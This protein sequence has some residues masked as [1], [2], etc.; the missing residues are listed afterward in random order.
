LILVLLS[1]QS[2]TGQVMNKEQRRNK[3]VGGYRTIDTKNELAITAAELVLNNL[4]SGKGPTDDYSFVFPKGDSNK[5]EVKILRA[6][7]QV[8]AGMNFKL[9]LGI[10]GVGDS[11]IGGLK[12]TT[13]YK[14]LQGNFSV[15][16]YGK[17]ISCDRVQELSEA[18]DG[19]EVQE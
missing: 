6:S 16:S 18:K 7:S 14:D 2:I 4:K 19:Q 10:Y 3:M 13:V 5:I 12:K 17:E 11:C 1:I 8:V 15:T 9:E